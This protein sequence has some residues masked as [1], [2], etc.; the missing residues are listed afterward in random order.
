MVGKRKPDN[1]LSL[2]NNL[3]LFTPFPSIK[4]NSSGH[5][6]EAQDEQQESEDL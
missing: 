5:E 6:L 4:I 1:N 2:H 3:R